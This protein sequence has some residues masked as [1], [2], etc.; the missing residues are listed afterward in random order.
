MLGFDDPQ[1]TGIFVLSLFRSCYM[2]QFFDWSVL[3]LSGHVL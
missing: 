1:V 3:T 2:Q